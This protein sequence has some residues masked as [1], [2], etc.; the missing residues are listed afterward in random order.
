MLL[1]LWKSPEAIHWLEEMC[2][3]FDKM[4]QGSYQMKNIRPR[5]EEYRRILRLVKKKRTSDMMVPLQ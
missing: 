4:P 1:E 5:H 2:Q 3:L